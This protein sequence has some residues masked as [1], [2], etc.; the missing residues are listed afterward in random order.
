[1]GTGLYNTGNYNTPAGSAG[2]VAA[3][4]EPSLATA[5][6]LAVG[7]SLLLARRRRSRV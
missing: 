3:V 5:G 1:L 2:A 6:L 7:A 4:P